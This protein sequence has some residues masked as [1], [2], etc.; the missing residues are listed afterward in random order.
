MNISGAAAKLFWGWQAL[1]RGKLSRYYNDS[2]YPPLFI[3]REVLKRTVYLD[4]FP[5]QLFSVRIHLADHQNDPHL[6]DWFVT[7]A[8]CLHVYPSLQDQEV[9]QYAALVYANCGRVENLKWRLPYRLPSFHMLELVLIDK[10]EVI[11]E[12]RNELEKVARSIL[13]GQG[14][15]VSPVTATDAFFLGDRSGAQAFQKL[16]QLKKEFVFEHDGGEVA[17]AS[18]NHHEDFFTSRFGIRSGK[19]I[20]HSLCLAFGIERLTTAS[21]AVWGDRKEGWPAEFRKYASFS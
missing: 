10:P 2:L 3:E 13:V 1:L 5:H 12:R 20:A 18:I 16:K 7:P 14:L 21:L 19:E 17:L 15:K 8:A 9:G 11:A 4:H 6:H